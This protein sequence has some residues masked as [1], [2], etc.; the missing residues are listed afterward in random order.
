MGSALLREAEGHARANGATVIEIEASL[1][2]YQR[3]GYVAL[4][5]GHPVRI[6]GQDIRCVRMR[7][8]LTTDD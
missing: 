1:E 2:F 4:D 3:H 7:K 5:A 8:R 6:A